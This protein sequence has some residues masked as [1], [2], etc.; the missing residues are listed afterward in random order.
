MPRAVRVLL[1]WLIAAVVPL[2]GLAAASLIAC[3]P[4]HAGAVHADPAMHGVGSG[5]A[6]INAQ[7]GDAGHADSAGH[8]AHAHAH[9]LDHGVVP[10]AQGAAGVPATLDA[11]AATDADA[12]AQD[13]TASPGLATKCSSCA[14]CCAAAAPAPRSLALPS[15][16][17]AADMVVVSD[18]RY[19]GIVCDIP[20]RPPRLILA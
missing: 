10:Q 1:I 8:A 20:H 4:G 11:L 13:G 19:V 17:P 2:K 14:P 7:V 6:A 9:V 3:G 5:H 12:S 15:V 18:A 16:A